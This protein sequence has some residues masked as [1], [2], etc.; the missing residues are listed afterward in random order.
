MKRFSDFAKKTNVMTGEKMKIDEVTGKEIEV[1]G[2]KVG[3]S[4]QKPGTKVLTLQFKLDGVEHIL[5]TGSNVL[6]EQAEQYEHE[7]PFL[8]TIEK[9]N[10]FYTFT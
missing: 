5:F 2:Y 10:K 3:N 4:K 1:L 9:V 6:L 8:T 7:M